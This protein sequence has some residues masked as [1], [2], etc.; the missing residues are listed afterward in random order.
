MARAPADAPKGTAPKDE[1]QDQRQGQGL[2]LDRLPTVSGSWGSG[3]VLTGK[4]FSLLLTDD[5]RVL[6]G[7]VSPDTLFRAAAD[8]AAALKASK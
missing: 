4:L 3:H 8:P 5:G 7:A 2:S 1:R 6:V